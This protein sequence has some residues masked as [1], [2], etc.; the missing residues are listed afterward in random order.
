MP[1]PVKERSGSWL[2]GTQPAPASPAALLRVSLSPPFSRRSVPA[3][4]SRPLSAKNP[5]A[6]FSRQGI[7]FLATR[8]L[9]LWHA[10]RPPPGEDTLE[11]HPLRAEL[12][13]VATPVP[14]SL[15]FEEW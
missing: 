4:R 11:T 15:M 5:R 1:H 14:S 10:R 9:G 13:H 8:L 6:M 3:R 7:F 12:S 2:E